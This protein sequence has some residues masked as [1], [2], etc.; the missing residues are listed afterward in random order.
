M[1]MVSLMSLKE[2]CSKENI[3]EAYSPLPKKYIY[4]TSESKA[5]ETQAEPR[6]TR[7]DQEKARKAQWT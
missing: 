7:K 1:L 3:G 5:R 4:A 2:W 6:E